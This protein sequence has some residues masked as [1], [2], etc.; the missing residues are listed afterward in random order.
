MKFLNKLN[1]FFYLVENLGAALSSSIVVRFFFAFGSYLPREI[2]FAQECGTRSN[3]STGDR[4]VSR[5]N[6]ACHTENANTRKPSRQKS[7]TLHGVWA[8]TWNCAA[9]RNNLVYR[10]TTWRF[11]TMFATTTNATGYS[12]DTRGNRVSSSLKFPGTG[13]WYLLVARTIFTLQTFSFN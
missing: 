4:L 11:V 8:S 2:H 3:V 1:N 5:G 12:R 9:L 7:S 10:L 6:D 13:Y